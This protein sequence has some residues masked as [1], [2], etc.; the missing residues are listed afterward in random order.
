M[1]LV[2][3]LVD[4]RAA[5]LALRRALPRGGPR[6]VAC[7]SSA[8][9][10]RHLE[11]HLTDAIILSPA[12]LGD[13]DGHALHASF[14]GIP[15]VVYSAFR[16]DDAPLMLE[17]FARGVAAVMVADVDDAVV[18]EL[19][20]RITLTARRR[21]D[22]ADAVRVLQLDEAIQR[23]AWE[24]LVS[25]VATPLRTAEL[26]RHL[27][28]SREHLSRQFG[29]GGAPNLKRVIDLTRVAAASQLLQ[30][31]GYAPAAAARLLGFSSP[32]HLNATATRI[33][34][35]G[36][37]GLARLG[38]RGVLAHFVR[39]NTRSRTGD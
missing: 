20:G 30:N 19:L 38:P 36:A 4:D 37:K 31:P 22:M 17:T 18:G 32:A 14:P 13:H 11:Q 24:R 8:S 2:A 25:D 26:A 9:L 21:A 27:G 35:V 15:T 5:L 3:A 34:G 23:R 39:G 10:H 16:P 12:R 29:A 6:L 33:A 28:V 1:S 7:R